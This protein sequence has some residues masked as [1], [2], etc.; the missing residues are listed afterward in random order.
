MK[1]CLSKT[2]AVGRF[3]C[4]IT[5]A[6]SMKDDASKDHLLFCDGCG[7]S[8]SFAGLGNDVERPQKRGEITS[9]SNKEHGLDGVI[10]V[11]GFPIHQ[12]KH[13]YSRTPNID[14]FAMRLL[15]ENIRT[16]KQ[17]K[18]LTRWTHKPFESSRAAS[19]K[20]NPPYE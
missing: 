19:S 15:L 8:G 2:S 10:V 9:N 18:K 13:T 5:S 4:S 16:N 3:S 7:A 11:R 20:V 14:W 1:G 6:S 17:T 12:L